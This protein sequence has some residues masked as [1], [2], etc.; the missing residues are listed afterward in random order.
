MPQ[1]LTS[2]Q[3][4]EL[5]KKHGKNILPQAKIPGIISIFFRQFLSPLIYILLFAALVSF[6]LGDASDAFFILLVLFMNSFIGTIQE[7]SAQK[8]ASSLKNMVPE[9]TN[10]LRD[11]QKIR[12][13]STQI[14]PGDIVFLESGD[15]VPADLKLHE[16]KNLSIDESMLTG[17]SVA[18]SKSAES[19]QPH[20]KSDTAF[21]GTMVAH[22]RGIGEVIA[23]ATH[24]KL[25]KIAISVATP[26]LAKPPLML[27]ME[28]F[29][30]RLSIAVLI[31]TAIIFLISW[32][33]G[34]D[35]REMLMT[36]AALAV[37]AIPEGLPAVITITLAIG[38]R[39]M[40]A[41]NVIIKK[42]LAVE[43][44]GSCTMI[45]SDKTGT[46]TINKL[47]ARKAV[48]P[49]GSLIDITG[50]E[51]AKGKVIVASDDK[52]D[53]AQFSELCLA[54][55]LTNEAILG[56]D[57]E[58]KGDMVDVAFLMLGLK[59][60]LKRNKLLAEYKE[61]TTIPYESENGYSASINKYNGEDYIFVKGSPEKLLQICS[62]MLIKNTPK[63]IN[64]D[65]ILKQVE[66]LA[67]DGYRLIGVAKGSAKHKIPQE[68]LHDLTFLGLVGMIDPLRSESREA[69][70]LCKQAG[71][72]VAM[73]T[74]DHPITA[75]AIAVDL[76]L[77]DKNSKVV[78]GADIKHASKLGHKALD[79]LV[80]K[81]M[82]FAR[83]E[84]E[85]KQQIVESLMRQGHFV[86]VTGDGVNDAPALRHSH[87]GVAMGKRG[88]DVA[89]E[90]A[91]LIITD[92]D[93]ASIV[94]GIHER[95]VIYN[96]I[97]KVIFMLISTGAAE[98]VLFILAIIAGLPLPLVATQLLWL[99]L[100][101]N[102]IQD[103]AMAFE[104]GEGDELKQPPRKPTEPIFDR[105]MIS[106]VV[107]NALFIGSMA[108]G[109]FQW[110][111]TH[112]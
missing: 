33:R 3:A 70:E 55:I 90:S 19:H 6:A 16:T 109:A 21:A 102:G 52:K 23:T 105:L 53:M 84:P 9:F 99:N 62:K 98:I 82:V 101:T 26:S 30:L 1:G 56:D 43:A 8:A 91:D 79:K 32:H 111:I 24:T 47:T 96:N 86:A 73:I 58:H 20:K 42:L 13:E 17:E 85:Q 65:D 35:M 89:K 41:N 103:V 34:G 97:R 71:I 29:T 107:V 76:G 83:I 39:R 104:P 93:F 80:A 60:G 51:N 112:G 67:Q 25:G 27:R 92:D 106:R 38:M 5:L 11:G 87:V 45:A 68:N 77:C 28:K 36:A 108:F 15:K 54:G 31:I 78:S 95:R 50:E 18:T 40:A 88:T 49:D 61:I 10:L 22:G 44:L 4:N 12:L 64:K 72:K 59:A 110:L 37:T 100:V 69:V 66:L 14:A 63:S 2:A 48:L 57:G 81:R 94:K 46:L 74:G 75:R 7:Y